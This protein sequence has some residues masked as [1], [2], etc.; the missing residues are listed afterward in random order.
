MRLDLVSN[1]SVKEVLRYYKL[2]LNILCMTL[3]L[4]V[5]EAISDTDKISV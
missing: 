3:S 1:L 2:V 4:T 5:T